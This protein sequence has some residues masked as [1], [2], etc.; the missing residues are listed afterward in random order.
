MSE[1]TEGCGGFYAAHQQAIQDTQK[2]IEK[3]E[4]G[5]SGMPQEIAYIKENMARMSDS[6]SRLLER[7]DSHFV[8]KEAQETLSA[9]LVE[10]KEST[11]KEIAELK[12]QN[13]WLMRGLICALLVAFKDI[14][15]HIL[16][17]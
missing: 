4:N 11:Q 7:L 6:M 13:T 16:S 5:F 8:T 14:A 15:L 9:S 1:K 12:N 10:F 3:L 2:R 17:K